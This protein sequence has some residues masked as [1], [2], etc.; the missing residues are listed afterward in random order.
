MVVQLARKESASLREERR[1][2]RRNALTR[3]IEGCVLRRNDR[4]R[5][6]P[7]TARTEKPGA[8]RAGLPCVHL[9]TNR[10]AFRHRHLQ[11]DIL[12]NHT[13][14]G[15]QNECN[16][17]RGFVIITPNQRACVRTAASP[18]RGDASPTRKET[19]TFNAPL[20][21]RL[22]PPPRLQKDRI[23]PT[24]VHR[25]RFDAEHKRTRTECGR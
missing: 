14:K 19:I 9:R 10:R 11:N 18:H 22:D 7:T 16:R 5:N 21:R 12:T 6:K 20:L 15:R 1:C 13:S 3:R 17:K 24:H 2:M 4:Y 25:T 8:V 23:K